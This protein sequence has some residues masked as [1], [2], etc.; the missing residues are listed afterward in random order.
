MN[1]VPTSIENIRFPA[2]SSILRSSWCPD[3]D[4]VVVV[5][6]AVGKD[7]ISLWKMTGSKKWE[8]DIER[9]ST[10]SHEIVDIAWSP[11]GQYIAVA[12]NPPLITLHSLQTGQQDRTLPVP[13][14]ASNNTTLSHIWW[15]KESRTEKKADIPDIFKRGGDIAGSAHAILRTQPLLDALHDESQP[16]S[17]T[18]LFAFK[19]GSGKP[20][21]Q[22]LVPEVISSWPTLPADR[23]A[24]SIQAQVAGSKENHPG[25][26]LDETDDSNVNSILVVSDEG[27]NIYGFLDGSYPLGVIELGYPSVIT[28]I[29][30]QRNAAL[31]LHPQTRSPD[32]VRHTALCP[33]V[34]Y[35]PFL[36]DRFLRDLARASS[37]CR[38]L[39][40][41]A[42]RVVKEMQVAWFGSP[43]NTGARE[44][45]PNWVKALEKRQRE[46]FGQKEPN[47]ILDLAMLLT[48][49]KAS[50]AIT[51]FF[52]SGELMSERGLQKWESS[53]TEAL[54]RLRDYSSRRLAPACQRLHI[55]L[56]EVYGWSRLPQYSSSGL[57]HDQIK[58]CMEHAER[59][60][61]CA[62]WLAASARAELLRFKEFMI[63]LRFEIARPTAAGADP[64]PQRHDLLE[65]HD[66]L[67]SGLVVSSIDKWFTGDIPN[68]KSREFGD[69]T[70][71]FHEVKA[72]ATKARE[73]IKKGLA[74][75]PII[76]LPDHSR[77]NRNL[78]LL[79]QDLSTHCQAI[80]H[81]AASATSS[82][83]IVA[84]SFGQLSGSLRELDM[85]SSSDAPTFMRERNDTSKG[86][87]FLQYLAIQ[88]P[89]ADQT[90]YLFLV[91]M[92]HAKDG[93]ELAHSISFVSLQC[94]I[95][96][97]E[98]DEHAVPIEVLDAEFFDEQVLIIVY[99]PLDQEQGATSIATIGY[100][101]LVYE[102]APPGHVASVT[103]EGLMLDLLQRVRDGQIAAVPIPMIGCRD[104]VGCQDGSTVSLA[105]N[106]RVGR[107]VACVLDSAGQALEV[108]DM[109]GEEDEEDEMETAAG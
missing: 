24:A 96:P 7:K 6:H 67:D 45:G 102:D 94:C 50:D 92:H 23:L 61:I 101:D 25:E 26:E 91:R 40:W 30:N 72:A 70:Q 33:T 80:F 14:H 20:P 66:Y 57:K 43:T 3:K 109:E 98:A 85:H 77:A 106:G 21:T 64:I 9:E 79:V 86:N 93:S 37:S 59:A 65:V 44:L 103:R 28:S 97:T 38:E 36:G 62:H 56:Q 8:V 58:F 18:D 46:G 31:F 63:W 89:H 60:V 1:K 52:G 4:L 95:A 76:E 84:G 54:T 32:G 99:R 105:V 5:V 78:N 42:I 22:R 39:T 73:V 48:T 74:W 27:G 47:A 69:S 16:L 81:G 49:G 2:R 13:P 107:R 108:L 41:Y 11:D 29:H 34:V 83:A 35:T 68:Y 82:A 104:L 90:S 10:G 17:A 53:V 12:S 88:T 51:D 75:P 71:T 15:L 19:G 55:V 87:S 100:A